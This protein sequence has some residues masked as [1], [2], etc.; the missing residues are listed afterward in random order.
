MYLEAARASVFA[1]GAERQQILSDVRKCDPSRADDV[2]ALWARLDRYLH[3]DNI[4]PHLKSAIDQLQV[5]RNEIDKK[6]DAAWWRRRDNRAAAQSFSATLGELQSVLST[7]TSNFYPGGSGMGI[8]TLFPI[9]QHISQ[10]RDAHKSGRRDTAY[11]RDTEILADLARQALRDQSHE[12]WFTTTA[13]V[14][15]LVAELELA[16]SIKADP[17]KGGVTS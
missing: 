3:D 14:D 10:L 11:D 5:C 4:R 1:L 8:Q 16:F 13:K 9:Y 6:S 7:L 12:Q 17:A 15:A 2:T